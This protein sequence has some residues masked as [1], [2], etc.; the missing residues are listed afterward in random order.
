[1]TEDGASDSSAPTSERKLRVAVM[2]DGYTQAGWIAHLLQELQTSTTAKIVV[3]I[4]NATT[5]NDSAIPTRRGARAR[6]AGWWRNR[7]A[8]PYAAYQRWDRARYDAADDPEHPVDISALL[9]ACSIV[10]VAPRMTKFADYFHD[11]SVAA[12]RAHDVDVAL[13]FGFRILKGDALNIAR[14]GVWSFHHG[15]NRVNRGG[16]PGFWE[17]VQN[18]PVTGAILQVL[19]EELDA[20]VVLA[21]SFSSTEPISPTA[22]RRA[23]YWQA[24]SMLDRTLR[25]LHTRGAAVIDDARAAA[26]WTAY[27]NRLYVAPTSSEMLRSWV[28]LAVRLVR[29]RAAAVG[30]RHQWFLAYRFVRNPGERRDVPDGAPHRFRELIPPT[31]RFW[32]DPIPVVHEGRHLVFFEEYVFGTPHGHISVLEIDAN[33]APG[34]PR[35]VLER[36]YHLSYPFVFRWNDEWYMIP[37]TMGR[38]SVELYRASAFPDAWIFDRTLLAD[39]DA[40]DATVAEIGDRWWMFA[41]VAAPNTV[42]PGTLHIYHASSPLGPWTPH[43]G[44]PVKLDIR[45]ARPA[46]PLFRLNGALYRPAQD[47]AP[48]YGSAIVVHRIEALTPTTFREIEVSRLTPS[49]RKGLNGT[50]TIAAAGGLTVID[51]RRPIRVLGRRRLAARSS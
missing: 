13:R 41:A 31:D 45:S 9:A 30:L 51:V 29:R 39:V 44:N 21:R 34:P 27:S 23:Y 38:R 33:G 2:I 12:I 26:G 6:V 36:P 32:A 3:V 18:E 5:S 48:L 50:H 10:R 16:P 20:G 15:D 7:A 28:G 46:G 25:D 47:G 17:V 1:M 19:S 4:L 40:A 43:T 35:R 42:A 8:L 22:N 37:E 24:G 14:Y 49:W 11:A